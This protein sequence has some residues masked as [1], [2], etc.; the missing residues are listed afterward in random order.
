LDLSAEA[1][2]AAEAVNALH[3]KIA[4][5]LEHGAILIDH[6]LPSSRP[7]IPVLSLAENPLLDTWLAAVETYRAEREKMEGAG[8]CEAQ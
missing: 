5:R 3:E 4:R 2:S 1:E 7:A 8:A 6:P